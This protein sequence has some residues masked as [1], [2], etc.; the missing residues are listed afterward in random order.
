[1]EF[2]QKK[3]EEMRNALQL[4]H[5]ISLRSNVVNKIPNSEAERTTFA[6]RF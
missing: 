4:I 3:F 2:S 6:I 1:M 5:D